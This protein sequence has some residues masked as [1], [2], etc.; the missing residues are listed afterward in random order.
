[1]QVVR[2][3]FADWAEDNGAIRIDE[4][5]LESVIASARPLSP[6]DKPFKDSH[7]NPWVSA[8]FH[9]RGQKWNVSLYLGGIGFITDEAGRAGAFHFDAAGPDKD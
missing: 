7:F 8:S 2:G 3:S 6:H 1:V 9:C 5:N 4:S